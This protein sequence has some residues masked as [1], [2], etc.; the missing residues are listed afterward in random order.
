[1]KW[2]GGYRGWMCM[3]IQKIVRLRQVGRSRVGCRRGGGSAYLA[4]Y[5]VIKRKAN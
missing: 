2:M 1:V 4:I 3:E 5:P